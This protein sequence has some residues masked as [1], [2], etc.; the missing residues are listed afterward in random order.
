LK[1]I[2]QAGYILQKHRE[3]IASQTSY[4]ISWTYTGTETLGNSDK[5]LISGHMTEAIIHNLEIVQIYE[6]NG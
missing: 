5:Q 1:D 3:L 4:R 2:F 6:E